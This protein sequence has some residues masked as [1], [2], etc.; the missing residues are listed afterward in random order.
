VTKRG[1]DC[2]QDLSC[3]PGKAEMPAF[4]Y[5]GPDGHSVSRASGPQA[6]GPWYARTLKDSYDFCEPQKWT[7]KREP[8]LDPDNP[9]R[10]TGRHWACIMRCVGPTHVRH[11]DARSA[12]AEMRLVVPKT[13]GTQHTPRKGGFCRTV[14]M[15][16]TGIH[17]WI[18]R[19]AGLK[20]TSVVLKT[21]GGSINSRRCNTD[22]RRCGGRSGDRRSP[23]WRWSV[24][25]GRWLPAH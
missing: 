25:P 9:M 13:R 8:G 23:A 3:P 22:A 14:P 12:T 10:A 18:R 11:T 7:V 6:T 19:N 24:R 21:A 2:N 16:L 4:G 17:V 5:P 15:P 1:R 20:S